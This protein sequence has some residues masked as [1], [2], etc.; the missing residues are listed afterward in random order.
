MVIGISTKFFILSLDGH[1]ID[2]EAVHKVA[3]LITLLR[4]WAL[5]VL[6][7]LMRR[8]SENIRR[9][10][11]DAQEEEMMRP[12]TQDVKAAMFSIHSQKAPGP[13]GIML[14]FS[15]RNEVWLTLWSLMLSSL[16]L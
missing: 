4:S 10:L 2:E 16:F 15:I 12:T 13:D 9:R 7:S 3:K 8:D 1:R 11:T 6:L 5:N 14:S